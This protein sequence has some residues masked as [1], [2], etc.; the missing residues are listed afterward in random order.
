MKFYYVFE[1]IN[2]KLEFLLNSGI[3]FIPEIF[4]SKYKNY[5]KYKIF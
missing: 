3:F 1:N 4:F 2:L 5:E